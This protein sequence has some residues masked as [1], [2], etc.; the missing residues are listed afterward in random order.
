MELVAENVIILLEIDCIKLDE[1]SLLTSPINYKLIY[2][3]RIDCTQDS[4]K[5]MKTVN[6]I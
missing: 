1:T 6:T 5:K 2:I 3:T 4:I